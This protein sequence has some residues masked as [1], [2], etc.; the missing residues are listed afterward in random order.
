[1]SHPLLDDRYRLDGELGRGGMA[2]VWRGQDVHLDRPVAIKVL[3]PAR[4]ADPAALQRLH[5]EARTVARLAHPN[6]VNVHDFGVGHDIAYLVMELVD[7]PS[8]ADL[9]AERG[10]L[11]VGRAAAIAEQ[12]CAALAAAHAAGVIHRDVK[13]GNILLG[14]AD[15]VKVCDFGIARL[16]ASRGQPALTAINTVIGT[17]EYMAPEQAT[18]EQA[19]AR[20]DLYALGC[21]LYAMLSGGPPFTADNPIAVF[22][23]HLHQP[24]VPLRVLHPHVPPDL[25]RLVADLLAKDPADRPATADQAQQRLAAIINASPAGPATVGSHRTWPAAAAPAEARAPTPS[26]STQSGS[27]AS[28]AGLPPTRLLPGST[29]DQRHQAPSAPHRLRPWVTPRTAAVAAAV[30]AAALLAAVALSG[31]SRP[32]PPAAQVPRITAQPTSAPPSS[33]AVQASTLSPPSPLTPT[34]RLAAAIPQQIDAGTLDP[35]A[36]RD[37]LH[38]LEEI[39]RKL[40]R[41]DDI[42]DKLAELGRKLTKLRRDGKLTTAG[43]DTLSSLDPLLRTAPDDSDDRRGRG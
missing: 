6:I 31:T 34:A 35:E 3:D 36:G 23:L 39:D 7:G 20:S 22:H 12:T 4:A 13:P 2:T 24:P 32:E 8:L 28:T 26:P 17:C 11:P 38:K 16:P 9:L 40:T 33:L 29:S 27:A 43:Y 37:L 19:D 10:P 5:R 14:P 25:D 18:G 41:G 1:M 15:T 42:N 21:V 30:A